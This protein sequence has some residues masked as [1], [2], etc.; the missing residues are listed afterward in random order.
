MKSMGLREF[1]RGGYRSL[2]ETTVVTSHGR[3]VATWVP[4]EA[5]KA[6][7]QRQY[8]AVEDLITRPDDEKL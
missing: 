5:R 8:D 3:T 6:F 7:K 1:L 2:T 4:V